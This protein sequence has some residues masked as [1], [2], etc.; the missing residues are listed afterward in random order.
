MAFPPDILDRIRA[1]FPLSAFIGRFVPLKRAGREHTGLCPFHGEKTPSFTVN[2]QKQ[3][4]HCF[5]CAAHGDVIEFVKR[6]ER[7]SYPE[8]VEKL[9]RDLYWP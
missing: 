7:L 8:A 9:A 4:F 2:D 3:F 1:H 6:Y 5:G